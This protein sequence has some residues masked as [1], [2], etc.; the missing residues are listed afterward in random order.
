MAQHFPFNPVAEPLEST[1]QAIP[2]PEEAFIIAEGILH[3]LRILKT[4]RSLD[5]DT[6][7]PAQQ[8]DPSFWGLANPFWTERA[9]AADLTFTWLA[10]LAEARCLTHPR[11]LVWLRETVCEILTLREQLRI[12]TLFPAHRQPDP[13]IFGHRQ[14]HVISL[15]GRRGGRRSSDAEHQ[16]DM[17]TISASYPQGPATVAQ[18]PVVDN[19]TNQPVFAT[20]SPLTPPTQGANDYVLRGN[21][22]QRLGQSEAARNPFP[23]LLDARVLNPGSRGRG[24][25]FVYPDAAASTA[26]AAYY[27][28]TNAATLIPVSRAHPALSQQPGTS[29]ATV[30]RLMGRAARQAFQAE[31][32]ARNRPVAPTAATTSTSTSM[33]PSDLVAATL[34]AAQ[35]DGGISAAAAAVD[36]FQSRP[37]LDTP[38][39]GAHYNARQPSPLREYSGTRG[40]RG[41]RDRTPAQPARQAGLLPTPR[42][43]FPPPGRTVFFRLPADTTVTRVLD[44]RE[45]CAGGA[46]SAA[47][48]AAAAPIPENIA[49]EAIDLVESLGLPHGP[50]TANSEPTSQTAGA[51]HGATVCTP[52]RQAPYEASSTTPEHGGTNAEHS[53]ASDNHS[54]RPGSDPTRE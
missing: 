41:T 43:L 29:S 52:Q 27:V 53:G 8:E 26:A 11:L 19:R 5:R 50:S 51:D 13:Y 6:W 18:S 34:A 40:R 42:P 17:V 2:S 7:T 36:F 9:R 1:A 12:D 35:T 33:D 48:A 47:A 4:E 25:T 3:T 14:H 38:P 31:A 23:R 24:I 45:V 37:L 21:Q 30:G 32:E 54:G 46:S 39:P 10:A 15:S 49:D 44:G 22:F 20:T 16:P 28:P